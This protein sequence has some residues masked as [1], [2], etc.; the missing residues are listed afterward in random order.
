MT[1]LPPPTAPV[2]VRKVPALLRERGWTVLRPGLWTTTKRGLKRY[3]VKGL[4]LAE[5]ASIECIDFY[6]PSR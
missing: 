4:L 5:A 2:P 6:R 1:W 3:T